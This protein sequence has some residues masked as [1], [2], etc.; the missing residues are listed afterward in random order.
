MFSSTVSGNFDFYTEHFCM[1]KIE[2]LIIGWMSLEDRVER[3][4][5]WFKYFFNSALLE[6][7]PNTELFLVRIFPYSYRMR[8]N[9]DQK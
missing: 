6:K 5:S 8:E 1:L 3:K 4:D 9:T 2:L 7:C